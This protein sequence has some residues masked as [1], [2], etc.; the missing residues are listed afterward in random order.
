M[1]NGNNIGKG[2]DT[3]GDNLVGRQFTDGSSQFTLGNFGINSGVRA[4]DSREFSL[5]NFS[6]PITLSTLNFTST[7]EAR[8]VSSNSLEVFINYDRSKVSN[9]VLYGSLRDRLRVAVQNVIKNFPAALVFTK[10]RKNFL[11]GNTA[12][13]IVF[14]AIENE[15]TLNLELLNVH[16]P[17]GIDFTKVGKIYTDKELNPVRNFTQFYN[18]YSLF[19]REEE[20]PITFMSPTTGNTVTD[21]LSVEVYGNPFTGQTTTTE[22][23][24]IKPNTKET[25][26]IFDNLEDV[27]KFI[28]ERDTTPIY[29][30]NFDIPTQTDSGKFV[31]NT[32]SLT[33]PSSNNWNLVITGASFNVYL[34]KLLEIADNFDAYKT[35]LVSRFLTTAAFKEFDTEDEKVDQILK[36]Y[37]RSFDSIKTYIEGL[38]YMTNVTYDSNNNVPNELLKNFAHTLG[39]KTPSAIETEGFLESVLKRGKS[40]YSGKAQSPTPT[41]LNSELYRRLLVNTA[42]L[43]K[44]KGTRKAIEF[45]MRFV[46]APEALIEFN[47]HVYVAGQKIDMNKF[48]QRI[49]VIS[50]GTYYEEIVVKDQLFSASTP[51]FPPVIVTGYTFGTELVSVDTTATRAQF[52]V[53]S[54]G[55]P[56]APT[57][58]KDG[59]FQAGAGWFEETVEHRGKEMV[60]IES[61]VFTGNTPSVKTKLNK[62]TYGEPYL[63]LYRKFPDT[64]LGFDI[65]RTKDNKKSWVYKENEKSKRLYSFR[66]R[67]TRYFTDDER[68]V[69]NVKN[70][71]LFLNVGQGLTWDVW[72][73]SNKF[74]CPFG[75]DALSAPYPN[76]G[77]PDWTQIQIDASKMPFVEFADQFWKILI[78]VKNRQ[79]IDDGHAGGYPTL[80]KVYLDYLES[81]VACGIPSNKYTYQKMIDYAEGI[82]DYWMRLVE[83]FI[84]ATTIW[85]GGTRY[86]NSE[87]HRYKYSYKHGPLCDDLECFGSFIECTGPNFNQQIVDGFLQCNGVVFSGATW[88]NR[89][90][91]GGTV[92]EGSP[93]GGIYYSS[94]TLTDIPSTDAWI[95]DVVTILSGITQDV[96]DPNNTLTWYV[97]DDTPT[98]P[99]LP[100]IDNPKTIIVQGPCDNGIDMWNYVNGPDPHQFSLDTC[101]DMQV[102]RTTTV[103]ADTDI[104]VYYDSTS[105]GITVANNAKA[106]LQSW[107]AGFDNWTGNLYHIVNNGERWLCAAQYPWTG[108]MPCRVWNNTNDGI[109]WNKDATWTGFSELPNPNSAPY[110]EP[111]VINNIT[112]YQQSYGSTGGQVGWTGGSKDVLVVMLQDETEFQYHGGLNLIGPSG[113]GPCRGIANAALGF[114]AN[115]P[116]GDVQDWNS[117]RSGNNGNNI[118]LQIT[119]QGCPPYSME[120]AGYPN[121][122][123]NPWNINFPNAGAGNNAG[124]SG[125]GLGGGFPSTGGN[126]YPQG[127]QL[128]GAGGNV[129]QPTIPYSADFYTFRHVQTNYDSFRGFVYPIVRDSNAARTNFPL[130]VYG[131]M[132]RNTVNIENLKINPTIDSLGGSMSAMTKYNPYSGLTAYKS[133]YPD[134]ATSAITVT[135]TIT[136]TVT[137][138]TAT[139][140]FISGATWGPGTPEIVIDESS[141]IFEYS[142][143]TNGDPATG[144]VHTDNFNT[145]IENLKINYTG[146]TSNASQLRCQNPPMCFYT[147]DTTYKV[148]VS[149]A[150]LAPDLGPNVL[151]ATTSIELGTLEMNCSGLDSGL[152]NL[153]WG[154]QHNLGPSGTRVSTGNPASPC[155]FIN[156]TQNGVPIVNNQATYTNAGGNTGPLAGNDTSFFSEGQFLTDL[157]VFLG[158][159]ATGSVTGCTVCMPT[160]SFGC[161]GE[162]WNANTYYSLGDEVVW[163]GRDCYR[164]T[165]QGPTLT[166][167]PQQGGTIT[168]WEK[169]GG[170]GGIP[171]LGGN[172]FRQADDCNDFNE[173]EIPENPGGTGTTIT[174]DPITF[175]DGIFNV[176]G[177]DCFDSTYSPCLGGTNPASHPC[178]CDAI[179]ENV[180][181]EYEVGDVVCCPDGT[182]G[183][184]AG[185]QWILQA[186]STTTPPYNCGQQIFSYDDFC[187]NYVQA[188]TPTDGCW[189]PCTE[190]V[191]NLLSIRQANPRRNEELRL[192]TNDPEDPCNPVVPVVPDNPVGCNC[193]SNSE[194][195]LDLDMTEIGWGDIPDAVRN[196]EM[197]GSNPDYGLSLNNS[198]AYHGESLSKCWKAVMS[199][200]CFT[201]Y[202]RLH[203]HAYVKGGT[204]TNDYVETATFE[205]ASI[206]DN[207]SVEVYY[208][209]GSHANTGI[210]V[211]NKLLLHIPNSLYG[212]Q[213]TPGSYGTPGSTPSAGEIAGL[214]GWTDNVNQITIQ[215]PRKMAAS[216]DAGPFKLEKLFGGTN[217]SSTYL[218]KG[219]I[220]WDTPGT[221]SG[222]NNTDDDGYWE[223]AP[224]SGNGGALAFKNSYNSITKILTNNTGSDISSNSTGFRG[225]ENYVF[226]IEL[227]LDCNGSTPLG[228]EIIPNVPSWSPPSFPSTP[229]VPTTQP[230]PYNPSARSLPES[231]TTIP[232]SVSMSNLQS[233]GGTVKLTVENILEETAPGQNLQPRN[234]EISQSQVYIV[235]N[236][237]NFNTNNQI[238]YNTPVMSMPDG[239]NTFNIGY[240]TFNDNDGNEV[241][242][243]K[244]LQEISDKLGSGKMVLQ[245]LD[246]TQRNSFERNLRTKQ[247]GNVETTIK[248]GGNGGITGNIDYS[249]NINTTTKTVKDTY[250]GLSDWITRSVGPNIFGD[251]KVVYNENGTFNRFEIRKTPRTKQ[252][253]GWSPIDSPNKEIFGSTYSSWSS[254]RT[255]YKDAT[256]SLTGR[257]VKLGSLTTDVYTEYTN[258]SGYTDSRGNCLSSDLVFDLHFAFS[259]FTGTTVVP[260]YRHYSGD[261]LM[262]PIEVMG[263]DGL[264]ELVSGPLVKFIGS[265][266]NGVRPMI[267][268]PVLNHKGGPINLP[269]GPKDYLYYEVPETTGYRFQYKACL[270]FNYE[271]NGYCNYLNVYRDLTQGTFPTNDLQYKELINSA[272]IYQGGPQGEGQ[273]LQYSEGQVAEK[274]TNTKKYRKQTNPTFG[275][276]PGEGIQNFK[277]R[278]YLE[279]TISGTTSAV[280][281]T[282]FTVGLNELTHPSADEHLT[283]DVF[284]TD[285]LINY[286]NCSGTTSVFTR[287]FEVYLDSDVVNLNKGD[288]VRLKFENEFHSTTKNIN[289]GYSSRVDLSLG[290]DKYTNKEVVYKPWYR[291][292]HYPS[293][294][295]TS[296]QQMVWNSVEKSRKNIYSSGSTMMSLQEQGTL[297]IVHRPKTT[298]VK[299]SQN[300]INVR[301]F[302]RLTFL[303]LPS[304]DYVGPLML[305]K[306][307]KP[308]NHW[309]KAIENFDKVNSVPRITDYYLQSDDMVTIDCGGRNCNSLY[310]NLP[311][312][313]DNQINDPFSNPKNTILL[314]NRIRTKGNGR[315]QVVYKAYTPTI[316]EEITTY[317]VTPNPREA[318][319]GSTFEVVKQSCKTDEDKTIYFKDNSLIID[320]KVADIKSS[321]YNISTPID[322]PLRK[323][324]CQ[325][326]NNDYIE[327]NPNSME[328][329]YTWCCAYSPRGGYGDDIYGCAEPEVN[330]RDLLNKLGNQVLTYGGA[331]NKPRGVVLGKDYKQPKKI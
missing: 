17:F 36:I 55:Y 278:V 7:E 255:R 42:Y 194:V 126:V 268:P 230:C 322:S 142:C 200:C 178:A 217:G 67:G 93:N 40:E 146:I 159:G 224:P 325:C 324:Y 104:F 91:L 253:N 245:F 285:N 228:F 66:D 249:Q 154:W 119:N 265:D 315:T 298:Q 225:G 188:S 181:F 107:V 99:N 129:I 85:Q 257:V 117:G 251:T 49:A 254:F 261:T 307:N 52:P 227:Q 152:E 10:L 168:Y 109:A 323:K 164:M 78:N 223:L 106:T 195:V 317:S 170:T 166:N 89:L 105:M 65:T 137:G 72:N 116:T 263:T 136:S 144:T 80:L 205:M 147:A 316:T 161:E 15:T 87:F 240:G 54:E 44:S 266:Y 76:I 185:V 313:N 121:T 314:Q 258:L 135:S 82:G 92:Y 220:E 39:W 123:G 48:N 283:L 210:A 312:S 222:L 43:F 275:Y 31:Q 173:V 95:E 276:N 309:V 114:I 74:G 132:E 174:V 41:A 279:K 24:F 102:E 303:D 235:E 62:F 11:T 79:T 282:E 90:T 272:I 291:I 305:V 101:L 140:C 96:G 273:D 209:Q 271:D 45:L 113:P 287:K 306:T 172:N 128:N 244:W 304:K 51:T 189:T 1:A 25:E 180:E 81:D 284:P 23:F 191:A 165:Q 300:P 211:S 160:C 53:N 75:K 151:T 218:T 69:L 64:N 319:N 256:T 321:S 134:A 182:A 213:I 60:D 34:G 214:V 242:Q 193:S 5:G 331:T 243:L 4:K 59:F 310:W 204:S 229:V 241:T 94:T 246:D 22:N 97:H 247:I 139:T 108:Q 88:S 122:F 27:E 30:A 234:Y 133:M 58:N 33:W 35:N 158:T 301:S 167:F 215:I 138:Y 14:D 295:V 320:G 16:N 262:P 110:G 259:A 299:Y 286:Y 208:V 130:H 184:A 63:N 127:G 280:T 83:Q 203:A 9:F 237:P 238:E 12:T 192:I 206:D 250:G 115:T 37:G 148:Y 100:F 199:I 231:T 50:G 293:T 179:D 226:N 103:G 202:F 296:T 207:T 297:S 143:D 157:N 77:G 176:G 71:D 252:K 47:E 169:I 68:L 269:R 281:M 302:N 111:M 329:C 236:Y 198:N 131:A 18:K 219:G 311:I 6:E 289:S 149:D 318:F 19:I 56:L 13:N 29:T 308:T 326:G 212:T 156:V 267:L 248:Y 28:I 216:N 26:E 171:F 57:F 292:T 124:G 150:G 264:E 86:E 8:K 141:G 290:E 46:G 294:G 21:T 186:Q 270:Y 2:S 3:F 239:K 328:G 120:I 155:S 187:V 163:D 260:N 84:P 183:F 277:A 177:Q 145:A 274:Y 118:S 32:T 98:D 20:Y 196:F 162:E 288:V 125:D 233:M 61:S 190:T 232:E 221:M 73:L 327:I 201:D 197:T 330:K 38:A 175:K 112:D 153:G 70:V